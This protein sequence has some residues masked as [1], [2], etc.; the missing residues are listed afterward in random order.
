M[1]DGPRDFSN[2]PVWTYQTGAGIISTP[3]VVDGKVYVASNDRNIY[4]IDAYNGTK[5]WNFTTAEPRMTYWGSSVAVYNGI[6]LVGPDDGQMYGLDANTGA[7]K[8]T[9]PMAKFYS[10]K[11]SLVSIT[12]TPRQ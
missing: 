1:D 5:I 10:I 6:V 12:F 7:V 4:C 3:V 2:G 11:I 9:T 8:W